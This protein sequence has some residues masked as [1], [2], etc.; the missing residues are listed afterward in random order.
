M[1]ER[2]MAQGRPPVTIGETETVG[3]GD[4]VWLLLDEAGAELGRIRWDGVRPYTPPPPAVR[5][6]PA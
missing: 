6:V 1:E 3:E 5:M 4:G 2:G